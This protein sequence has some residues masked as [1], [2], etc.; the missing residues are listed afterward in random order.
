M[1]ASADKSISIYNLLPVQDFQNKGRAL[2]RGAHRNLRK[3][4]NNLQ[5]TLGGNWIS[6]ASSKGKLHEKDS[7]RREEAERTPSLRRKGANA[8]M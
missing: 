8:R 1:L 4:A 3:I 6:S 7:R 2:K 5:T